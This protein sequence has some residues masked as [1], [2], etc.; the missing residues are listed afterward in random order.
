MKYLI[1]FPR[2]GN[3][4]DAKQMAN[5]EAALKILDH[6]A[7]ISSV[8]DLSGG[9]DLRLHL[10]FP[11]EYRIEVSTPD[12]PEGQNHWQYTDTEITDPRYSHEDREQRRKELIRLGIITVAG[13]FLHCIPPWGILSGVRPT[14]I[15]HYY[16]DQGFSPS[17]ITTKLLDI[18]GLDPSKAGLVTETGYKQ[19]KFFK[20][21]RFAGIYIGIPFCPSRCRYCSFSAVPLRTHGHLVKSFIHSLLEEIEATAALIREHGFAIDTIY[22]GGGT[23]TAI[24]DHLFAAILD[25]IREHLMVRNAYMRSVPSEDLEF[26]VEAGRPETI[27]W[28]KLQIMADGGVT[29]VSVN[30]QTMN[31]ATLERIGR[32]HTTMQVYDAVRLVQKLPQFSLN[33]D[34]ILGLPGENGA[35]FMKTLK[36]IMAFEPHNITIHTLAPKRASEWRKEFNT[37]ELAKEDDLRQAADEAMVR[38]RAVNYQPY[39]LYRQRYILADLENIGYAK[40]GFEN[41]Y[42]IQMMEERETIFGLGGGA[43]TKWVTSPDHKVFRHQNPKCPATY[44]QRIAETIVKKAQQTRLLLG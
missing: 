40:P 44:S 17:E 7:A 3:P 10:S 2:S 33:M 28:E 25:A 18:Y 8:P 15:F 37:L 30:P 5:I 29:R 20:K 21:G 12:L 11:D 35:D 38:L 16:R 19:E 34:L 32:N 6:N 14:K 43:V 23:P 22:M 36:E 26:T 4:S 9:F 24:D 13:R 27:T 42:N 31:P 41:I 1:D 39:Y